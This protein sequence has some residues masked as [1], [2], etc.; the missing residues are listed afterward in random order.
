MGIDFIYRFHLNYDAKTR[1]FFWKKTNNWQKG[2]IRAKKTQTLDSH[3]IN[4]IQCNIQ[5]ES[6][7]CHKLWLPCMVNIHHEE[8]PLL[9]V[10]WAMVMPDEHGHVY[11]PVVNDSFPLV[12]IAR[13]KELGF[14]ENLDNCPLKEINPKF[15][16]SVESSKEAQK[17]LSQPLTPE[18]EAYIRKA[19]NLEHVP[20][21]LRKA[22]INLRL[23]HHTAMS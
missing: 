2:S 18:K 22:Y 1:G 9:T 23:K 10:G 15:V 12:D 5:T 11:V 14:T 3:F 8:R 13:N 21:H 17:R 7:G 16:T 6:G 4:F 20:E 19:A